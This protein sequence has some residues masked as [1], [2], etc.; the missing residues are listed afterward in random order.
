MA[1]FMACFCEELSK[2]GRI[3]SATGFV[4]VLSCLV[5]LVVCNQ[6]YRNLFTCS[7][8]YMY[9]HKVDFQ[10]DTG[11]DWVWSLS[12]MEFVREIHFTRCLLKC[13]FEKHF[14]VQKCFL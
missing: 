14:F 7:E 10:Y 5:N 8:L 12:A 6:F 1:C 2:H 13:F 3:V 9:Q 4:I 11:F